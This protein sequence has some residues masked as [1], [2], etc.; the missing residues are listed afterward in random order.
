[1]GR[2]LTSRPR[3]R[4]ARKTGKSPYQTHGKS[5]FVYSAA[6]QQWRSQHVKKAAK[7]NYAAN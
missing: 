1:M 4:R 2:K 5:P 6:Y 3:S 7:S